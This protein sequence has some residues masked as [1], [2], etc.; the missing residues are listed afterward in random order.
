MGIYYTVIGMYEIVNVGVN[1]EYSF[2]SL[3]IK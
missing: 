1:Y 2:D 3:L